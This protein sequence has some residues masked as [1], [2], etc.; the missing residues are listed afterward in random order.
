MEVL[1]SGT[2]EVY[3]QDPDDVRAW[4]AEHKSRGKN[5]GKAH[6]QAMDYIQSLQREDRGNEAPQYV[7]VSDFARIAL[8]NLEEDV[9]VEFPLAEFHQNVNHFGFIPGYKQHKLEA[10]DPINIKAV[11]IMGDLHDALE[12][13]GYSGHELERLLVRVLFCLFAEDT[14][15]F[16]RNAF[17]L[18]L[19]NHTDPDGSNLGPLLAQ[20]FQV[21]N[22]P[23]QQ[24]QDEAAK[25]W[26]SSFRQLCEL[27]GI[28]LD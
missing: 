12:A 1:E 18:Y 3:I 19:E 8:H 10:E 22:K 23:M 16:E 4:M 17:Q 9:T 5:L 27:I 24:R 20:F 13:G 21:L 14:G 26:V 25:L 7:I 15:I 11:Q 2:G 28:R 6:A